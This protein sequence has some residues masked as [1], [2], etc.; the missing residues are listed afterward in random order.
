[1]KTLTITPNNRLQK[2]RTEFL[3]RQEMSA[4]QKVVADAPNVMSLSTFIKWAWEQ[5]QIFGYPAALNNVLITQEQTFLSW[6][7]IIKNDKSLI[8]IMPPTE[9]ANGAVRAYKHLKLWKLSETD[10]IP[11]SDESIRFQQWATQFTSNMK[12][13]V[14]EEEA[15]GIIIDA[16]SD[17]VIPMPEHISLWAFDEVPPLF[18]ALFEAISQC[19]TLQYCSEERPPATCYQT[20][21]FDNDTQLKNMAAWAYNTYEME[22]SSTIAIVVPDLVAKRQLLINALDEAFEPQVILPNT[23]DYVQPYNVSAGTPM[24]SQ[25]IIMLAKKILTVGAAS[26]DVATLRS[27]VMSP[28][29]GNSESESGKRALFDLTLQEVP[30]ELSLSQMVSLERCPPKLMASVKQFL[31]IMNDAPERDTVGNWLKRFES[32]LFAIGWPGE[33]LPNSKEYQALKQ[34]NE[35]LH[36]LC[37]H[38]NTDTV[39]R[40]TAIYYYHLAL[41]NTLYAAESKD[42][43][44]QV[45]GVLEAAGLTFD[46]I[47]ILDMYDT[48]WPA[49]ATPTP[50]LPE[51][52]QIEHGMPHS[53]ASRELEFAKVLD[54]RFKRSCN[55]L[56]YSYC[57]TEKERK[58]TPSIFAV[59]EHLSGNVFKVNELNHIDLLYKQIPV[60]VLQDDMVPLETEVAT[61]GV[62]L[63][64]D[65]ARCPFSA[66]VKHR[67]KVAEMPVVRMGFSPQQRGIILHE[68]LEYFWE[69]MKTHEALVQL[70]QEERAQKVLQSIERAFSAF[71][72]KEDISST[73][74]EMEVQLLSKVIDKW[75]DI[76]VQRPAFIVEE[77][78]QKKL[79]TIGPLTIRIRIDR[80]DRLIDNDRVVFIDYKSGSAIANKLDHA[81]GLTDVQLPISA[82][83]A[84][85]VD[86]VAYASLKTGEELYSGL[87]DPTSSNVSRDKHTL[88]K[89]ASGSM[90]EQ[91][92]QWKVRLE[93]LAEQY[94]EGVV[95]L[96]PSVASCQFCPVK[97]TCRIN[98]N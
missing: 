84:E 4:N 60:K 73:L 62:S 44:I 85:N 63:L 36:R 15:I 25:P 5:A 64:E 77:L 26:T 46:Y 72:T 96:T 79:V 27:I 21:S 16:I 19:T 34:H 22:P 86:T 94:A 68:V 80:K 11:D 8:T 67:L 51:L 17:K 87:A 33:R 91:I 98:P 45:L 55:S 50:F 37:S 93:T 82:L 71:T 28:F 30:T 3:V 92:E 52:L 42:C 78:E 70:T 18:Q 47:Y 49:K 97:L 20:A 58:L 13:K 14:T 31:K 59:G 41:S 43:P 40:D 39:T 38:Y 75:L 29:I 66:F 24:S 76:E 12:G 81:A 61:G 1:M 23:P 7:D 69:D 90:S 2:A 88:I 83:T 35:L 65:E 54:N 48:V 74:I 10:F 57:N 6:V 95:T 9:L 89:A 56:I 53:D 32:A